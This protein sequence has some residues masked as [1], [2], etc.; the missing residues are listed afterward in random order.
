MFQKED[1]PTSGRGTLGLSHWLVGAKYEN[2]S[3]GASFHKHHSLTPCSFC[4]TR[5][6]KRCSRVHDPAGKLSLPPAAPL[7]RCTSSHSLPSGHALNGQ[8]IP[9]DKRQIIHL[10]TQLETKLITFDQGWQAWFLGG[11]RF[12]ALEFYIDSLCLLAREVGSLLEL[13][14]FFIL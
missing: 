9:V 6:G 1:A 11:R 12:R 2:N 3:L 4:P 5:E 14:L 7:G 10:F 13:L 8:P